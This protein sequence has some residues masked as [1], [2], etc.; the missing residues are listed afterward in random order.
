MKHR[1][2]GFS[3]LELLVALSIAAMSLAALYH[4]MGSSTRAMHQAQRYALATMTAESLLALHP[5]APATGLDLRGSEAGFDW[6]VLSAPV[7]EAALEAAHTRLHD[8]HIHVSW[9]D[10]MRAQTIA[11]L[12]RV[13]EVKP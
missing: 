1:T 5:Q 2:R 12:T 11:L 13:P 8:L 9:Q 10:G 7:T 6:H 3:L 4:A